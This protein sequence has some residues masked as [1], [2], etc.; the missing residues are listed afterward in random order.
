[1]AEDNKGLVESTQRTYNKTLT[2]LN[3]GAQ[4]ATAQY[5]Q[6]VGNVNTQTQ[7][8]EQQQRQAKETADRQ[9]QEQRDKL[10]RD[11]SVQIAELETEAS[12]G[13]TQAQAQIADLQRKLQSSLS[14]A[15]LAAEKYLGTEN[16]P[17]GAP[18][19]GGVTGTLYEDR[20]K[21]IAARQ[22]TI[23]NDL[24]AASLNF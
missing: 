10:Q 18:T 19:I 16:M 13:N 3:A 22:D 17:T 11:Y 20:T 12:R 6:Q 23:Y 2:D 7:F 1:M 5:G 14:S 4:Y 21:D 24:T 8:S 15:G 9:I